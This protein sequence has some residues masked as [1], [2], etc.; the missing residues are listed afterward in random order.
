[1]EE[2]IYKNKNKKGLNP[3]IIAGPC[4]AETEEQTVKTALLISEI[5]EVSIYRAGIWKPRTK[6]GTFEGVGIKA[7]PWLRKVKEQTNLKVAVEVAYPEH[8]EICLKNPESIDMI[9]IGARTTVNPFSVQAI[10]DALQGS[11]IP[12]MIKNPINPDVGLW[13]GATERIMKSGVSDITAIH[14]GFYP[15]SE[16][17]LRNLP[18]WELALDYRLEFP[19]IPIVND[20][21]HISGKRKYL[22]SIAQR[23]MNLNFDGLMIETHISPETALSDSEQQLTPEALKELIHNITFRKSDYDDKIY[24]DILHE[25]REQIDSIDFQLLELL[26]KRMKVVE[27][28][29]DY[30]MK[31]NVSVFQLKRW[32]DIIQS[33]IELGESLGIDESFVKKMLQLVH[34]ESIKRQSLIMNGNE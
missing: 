14:R 34:Q 19:E 15:F 33:R 17:Y 6:P 27:N 12:V 16:T 5:P 29:G 11:S 20:P 21:S 1:M 22:Q 10:A 23:A 31:N 18:K 30:K 9:W 3:I 25:Y 32:V 8:V 26:S 4:S 13:K 24:K 28:I 2:Q 7:L